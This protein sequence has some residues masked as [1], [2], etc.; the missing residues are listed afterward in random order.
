MTSSSPLP[1]H[2]DGNSQGSGSPESSNQHYGDYSQSTPPTY[3]TGYGDQSLN[4]NN[5]SY[6]SPYGG[7]HG[8]GQFSPRPHVGFGEA[9]KKWKDNIFHFSGRASRSEYW[10][11]QL[12]WALIMFGLVAITFAVLLGQASAMETSAPDEAFT[13]SES[14]F[15]GSFFFAYILILVLGLV[16]GITTLALGWRRLQDAGFPG[17]LYLL[18]FVGLGIVPF[19]MC[20]MPSS[21]SG[22]QY[23]K[24]VDVNRP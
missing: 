15:L 10:W 5:S 18:N 14:W 13:T 3:D 21:P 2:N 17:G 4:Y 12:L 1:S 9:I 11:I 8:S 7:Y 6:G 24:P 19:I 23:D 20:L 16:Q 22:Y